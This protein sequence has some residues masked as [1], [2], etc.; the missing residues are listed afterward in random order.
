MP[1][2]LKYIRRPCSQLR[3]GFGNI[4][5]NAK[6]A[7]RLLGSLFKKRVRIDAVS[8]GSGFPDPRLMFGASEGGYPAFRSPPMPQ[9][10]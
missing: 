5:L 2:S 1:S 6:P 4:F 8:L 10:S 7:K 9:W 3:G